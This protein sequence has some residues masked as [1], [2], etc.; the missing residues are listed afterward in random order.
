M[1]VRVLP[2]LALGMFGDLPHGRLADIDY[3]AA[4]EVL[5]RDLGMHHTPPTR[6]LCPVASNR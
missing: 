6:R 1:T 2:P 4:A 3:G 5:R